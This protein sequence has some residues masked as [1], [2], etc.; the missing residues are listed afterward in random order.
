[1]P[2]S[3]Y[4]SGMHNLLNKL[5]LTRHSSAGRIRLIL[6]GGIILAIPYVLTMLEGSE[7]PD[8]FLNGFLSL[9]FIIIIPVGAICWA[10]GA[11]G[12]VQDNKQRKTLTAAAAIAVCLAIAAVTVSYHYY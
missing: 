4:T 8:S 2:P 10:A 3:V 5:G 11:F 12:S 9:S 7:N 1:M 6:L